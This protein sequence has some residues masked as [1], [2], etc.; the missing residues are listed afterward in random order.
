MFYLVDKTEDLSSGGSLS[1]NPE[2]TALRM[3]GGSWDIGVLQQRA[4]SRDKRLL[5]MTE[6]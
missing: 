4:S 5:L 1:S 3:S 2:K 6:K